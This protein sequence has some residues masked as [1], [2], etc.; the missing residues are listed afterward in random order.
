MRFSFDPQMDVR[1]T[2]TQFDGT[3]SDVNVAHRVPNSL[4]VL[5][6]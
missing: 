5:I 1:L 3:L 2:M 4:V 6:R